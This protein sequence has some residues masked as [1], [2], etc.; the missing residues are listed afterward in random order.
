MSEPDVTLTERLAGW[1]FLIGLGPLNFMGEIVGPTG[2]V[3][4]RQLA[5]GAVGSVLWA[6]VVM[7]VASG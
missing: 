4:W 7:F 3:A 5:A 6:T 2:A 1:A